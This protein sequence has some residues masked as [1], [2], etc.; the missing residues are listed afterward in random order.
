MALKKLGYKIVKLNSYIDEILKID[1]D[2]Y[3]KSLECILEKEK[4]V[5]FVGLKNII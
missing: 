3:D 4:K 1:F 5:I 2:Y